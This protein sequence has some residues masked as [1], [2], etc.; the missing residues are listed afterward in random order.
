MI[1][2][3]GL[4]QLIRTFRHDVPP[5]K[6]TQNLICCFNDFLLIKALI[7]KLIIE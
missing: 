1:R 7:C 4:I 5:P 6:K 2:M 3:C